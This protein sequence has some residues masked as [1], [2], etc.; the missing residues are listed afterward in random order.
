MEDCNK[1]VHRLSIPRLFARVAFT[2]HLV[3]DFLGLA[4]AC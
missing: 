1:D 3:T 4:E 2:S